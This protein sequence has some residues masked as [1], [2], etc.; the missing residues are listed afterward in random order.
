MYILFT[1]APGSKWSS[2]AKNIYWS[3]DIDQSASTSERAYNKGVVRHI[4]SYFDPGMEF[5]NS[6]DNWDLPFSGKGKRIIK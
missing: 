3:P 4:G 5:R 1:G 6:R 2:V